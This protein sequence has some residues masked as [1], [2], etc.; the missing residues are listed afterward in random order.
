MDI[1][2]EWP[3]PSLLCNVSYDKGEVVVVRAPLHS[4][5]CHLRRKAVLIPVRGLGVV[6]K[7]NKKPE[8]GR[9]S[10]NSSPQSPS[11]FAQ[12]H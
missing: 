1:S 9:D 5:V 3:S 7:I 8:Q 2:L 4:P 11:I 10:R 12:R 6:T